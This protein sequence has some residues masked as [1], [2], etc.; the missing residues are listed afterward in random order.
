MFGYLHTDKVDSF[1]SR[2]NVDDHDSPPVLLSGTEAT[3]RLLLE[4]GKFSPVW[5]KLYSRKVIGDFRF[6][7]PKVCEDTIFNMQVFQAMNMMA[8]TGECLYI[9]RDRPG[10]ITKMSIKKWMESEFYNL[11][12]QA[13]NYFVNQKV[14]GLYLDWIYGTM[15]SSRF[16]LLG[17]SGYKRFMDRAREFRR[18]T[19]KEFLFSPVISTGRKLAVTLAWP[20]PYLG[21]IIF[22]MM[23]N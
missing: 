7:V 18:K 1:S 11:A 16:R 6:T 17:D 8:L 12:A 9:L 20:F 13:D 19:F 15:Q 5:N 14:R 3:E 23:G 21:S 10:S 2:N 4:T 22:K